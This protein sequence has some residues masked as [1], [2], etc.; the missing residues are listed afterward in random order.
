M[1]IGAG[2]GG[3]NLVQGLKESFLE[4][5]TFNPICGRKVDDDDVHNG[6][7]T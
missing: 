1:L 3:T 6:N 7:K 5:A 2:Y 4:E